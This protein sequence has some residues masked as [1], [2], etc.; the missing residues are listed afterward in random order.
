MNLNCEVTYFLTR[1]VSANDRTEPLI[2][3]HKSVFSGG[4]DTAVV[5]DF[6]R[7][8]GSNSITVNLRSKTPATHNDDTAPIINGIGVIEETEP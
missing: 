5:K 4:P 1:C 6:R 3:A 8:A 2:V 7:V